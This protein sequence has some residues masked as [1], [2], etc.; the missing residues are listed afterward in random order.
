MQNIID[1]KLN[2]HHPRLDRPGSAKEQGEEVGLDLLNAAQVKYRNIFYI[3]CI[4][5]Q[6]F[7]Y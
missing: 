2:K 4:Y 3:V 5:I 6:N 1:K 7:I